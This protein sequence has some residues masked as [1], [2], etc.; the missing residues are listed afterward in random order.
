MKQ[1][2]LS[3]GYKGEKETLRNI[4]L[5]QLMIRNISNGF[6]KPILIFSII[7]V[8]QCITC[9]QFSGIIYNI[10]YSEASNFFD[11]KDINLAN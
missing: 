10:F 9:S 5:P 3:G 4:S 11:E 8:P 1:E 6:C 7:L 2:S